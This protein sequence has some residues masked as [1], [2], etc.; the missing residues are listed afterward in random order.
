LHDPAADVV[1]PGVVVLDASEVEVGGIS[2]G[3]DNPGFVGGRVEV[4]K[5]GGVFVAGSCETLIQEPRLRLMSRI[6]IQ[7]FFIQRFYFEIIKP[8]PMELQRL[9]HGRKVYGFAKTIA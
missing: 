3:R 9:A 6:S 8:V 2:V 7:I 1:A 5:R 4:T